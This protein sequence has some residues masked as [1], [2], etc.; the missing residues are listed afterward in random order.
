M[1]IEKGIVYYLRA[2]KMIMTLPLPTTMILS[3]RESRERLD[4]SNK[5]AS[6]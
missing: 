5:Q 2:W 6:I 3:A 1:Q 4:L